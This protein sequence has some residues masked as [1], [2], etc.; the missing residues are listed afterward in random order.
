MSHVHQ[1]PIPPGALPLMG[2]I[3]LTALVIT[4]GARLLALP[5]AAQPSAVAAEA[6]SGAAIARVAERRL[7]FADRADGAVVV[8]DAANGAVVRIEAPNGDSGFIR[9]VLRGFARERRMRGLGPAA[10]FTLT[11]W[12]NG[13]LSFADPATGRI[14]ELGGFGETNRA[15]FLSLLQPRE[16]Q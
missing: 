2:G 16:T 15:T 12:Q 10:P 6:G 4:T 7:T 11:L 8:R 1:N 9:G 3:V 14:A 13:Q 5:P